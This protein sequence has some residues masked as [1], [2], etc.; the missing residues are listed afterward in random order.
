M[1]NNESKR[2]TRTERRWGRWGR[3]SLPLSQRF[4]VK[5]KLS[6]AR[7]D[8]AHL[9]PSFRHFHRV[10]AAAVP[11]P[12]PFGDSWWLVVHHRNS[13]GVA[14]PRARSDPCHH[15]PLPSSSFGTRDR[16]VERNVN[17][18]SVDPTWTRSPVVVGRNRIIDRTS[19]AILRIIR[20]KRVLVARATIEN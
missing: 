13:T 8:I 3:S 14:R 19:R 16:K 20:R 1:E 18:R 5:E 4:S 9:Y 15:R 10:A 11:V 17:G 6:Y 7:D 12:F 2:D